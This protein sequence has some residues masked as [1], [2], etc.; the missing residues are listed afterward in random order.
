[1]VREFRGRKF[2]STSK[3]NCSIESI[4]DIVEV[5]EVSDEESS[6]TDVAGPSQCQVRDVRVV[7]VMP[8]DRYKGYLKC[9]TKLVPDNDD[10]DLGL[11]QKCNPNAW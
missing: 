8:L 1:M 11:C 4:S 7:G 9:K 6:T 5:A 2:L 10:P 3:E